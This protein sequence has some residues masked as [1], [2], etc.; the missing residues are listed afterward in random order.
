MP[1]IL[2]AASGQQSDIDSVSGPTTYPSNAGVFSV[3]TDLGRVDQAMV[4]VDNS[5][6]TTRVESISSN[7]IL[8]ISVNSVA[9]ATPV[10]AG[11][12]LSGDTFTY[13]AW[14]L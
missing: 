2:R 11:T 1:N 5:Q 13:A 3:R 6:L 7:N 10:Q 8:N 12:D 14:R 4:Q 9:T